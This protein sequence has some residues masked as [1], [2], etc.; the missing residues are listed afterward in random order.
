MLVSLIRA[1]NAGAITY[2]KSYYFIGI[3]NSLVGAREDIADSYIVE[4]YRKLLEYNHFN[5]NDL[6][7]SDD[8]KNDI[9]PTCTKKA[10]L[11]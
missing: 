9:R 1:I 6:N 2:N 3:G 4:S 11:H 8:I 10:I 5:V 7:L